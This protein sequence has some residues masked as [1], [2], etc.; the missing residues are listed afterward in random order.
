M[1]DQ[2]RGFDRLSLGTSTLM[3]NKSNENFMRNVKDAQAENEQLLIKKTEVR[4]N[5]L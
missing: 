3:S 1:D 4:N 2:R 5:N